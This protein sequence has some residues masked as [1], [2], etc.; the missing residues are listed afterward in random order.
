MDTYTRVHVY[1]PMDV[2]RV[3]IY[4]VT[5]CPFDIRSTDNGDESRIACAGRKRVIYYIGHR[6]PFR[7]KYPRWEMYRVS[8]YVWVFKC[9]VTVCLHRAV[10]TTLAGT[11]VSESSPRETVLSALVDNHRCRSI[12]PDMRFHLQP[13]L[14]INMYYRPYQW[15]VWSGVTHF[16]NTTL[17]YV[18]SSSGCTITCGLWHLSW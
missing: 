7:S 11:S 6:Q 12:S 17:C 5:A 16:L 8:M 13:W 1:I 4:D 9:A 15:R 3:C 10:M 14:S 18:A 2:N